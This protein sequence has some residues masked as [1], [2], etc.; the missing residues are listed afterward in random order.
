MQPGHKRDRVAD[1]GKTQALRL[2]AR[3]DLERVR[4]LRRVAQLVAEGHTSEAI[5]RSLNI[6]VLSTNRLERQIRSGAPVDEAT[7]AD[8]INAHVAGEIDER[9]MLDQLLAMQF[10]LGTFDPTGG[11]GYVAGSWDEV[12]SAAARGLLTPAQYDELAARAT[13]VERPTPGDHPQQGPRT[14]H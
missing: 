9:A 7:P 3:A 1:S 2:Q 14:E 11:T 5:A 8:V 4:L 12:Q 10:S 6:S 13:F